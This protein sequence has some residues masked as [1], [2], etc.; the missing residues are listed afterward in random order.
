MSIVKKGFGKN[1]K[2]IRKSKCITQE[3]LSE[4]IGIN[5]RQLARIEAGESFVTAETLERICLELEV[6]PNIL[7]NFPLSEEKPKKS[8]TK[9]YEIVKGKLNK[10]SH[11]K[12][13]L[14]FISLAFDALDNRKALSQLKY[15]LKG[16]ELSMKK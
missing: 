12:S 13:R 10:N 7:F 8:K 15:L 16:I 2:E 11:D 5:L 4:K 3:K 14:E 6:S 9:E 1:L